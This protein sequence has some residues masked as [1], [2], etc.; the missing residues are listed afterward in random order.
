MSLL[1]F[2]NSKRKNANSKHMVVES[3][4]VEAKQE[5]SKK[6]KKY[7]MTFQPNKVADILNNRDYM[8]EKEKY[9]RITKE[10]G[11]NPIF[12]IPLDSKKEVLFWM[13]SCSPFKADKMIILKTDKYERIDAAKWYEEKGKERK[14]D[15]LKPN[16]D[17]CI[18]EYITRSIKKDEIVEIVDVDSIVNGLL[19][20]EHMIN[21]YKLSIRS[22]NEESA[23]LSFLIWAVKFWEKLEGRYNNIDDTDIAKYLKGYF[24]KNLPLLKKIRSTKMSQEKMLKLTRSLILAS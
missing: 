4:K 20:N 1:S 14:H 2:V 19:E 23:K 13:I 8:V 21:A 16:C 12:L 5:N 6:E 10:F 7:F 17:D 3:G 22:G 18:C 24:T 9:A 15:S 11:Y